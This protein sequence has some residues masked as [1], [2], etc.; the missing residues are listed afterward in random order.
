MY[1][2]LDDESRTKGKAA[3]DVVGAQSGKSIGSM[4]QQ[5]LLILRCGQRGGG[6]GGGPRM[7]PRAFLGEQL[8]GP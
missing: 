2:G 3:I 6:A 1:I 4:L 5:A 8:R 7:C